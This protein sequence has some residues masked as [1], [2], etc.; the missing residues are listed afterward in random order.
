MKGNPGRKERRR[1]HFKNKRAAGKKRA[2]WN[3]Y[4][5]SHKFLKQYREQQG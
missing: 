5:S 1:L 2:K 3:E 4:V